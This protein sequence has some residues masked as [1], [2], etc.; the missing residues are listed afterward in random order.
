MFTGIVEEV[1]TVD[2]VRGDARILRLSVR[3]C[4]VLGETK[5]GD[6]ISV[7]GVCLTVISC[8]KE[9]FTVEIVPQTHGKTNLTD[10]KAGDPVNLERALA[11]GHRLGGHLVTGDIDGVGK[12]EHIR[13]GG[14]GSMMEIEPPRNLLKYIANQGRIAVDGVSLTVGEVIPERFR[15]YLVPFTLGHTTLG[16]KKRKSTV[17]L[18]VDLI[19]RYLERIREVEK[20]PRV[21][22]TQELLRA[23]GY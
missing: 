10:L 11:L 16:S 17:N 22:V 19:S 6:S 3:A 9:S 18:E 4:V 15:V 12:V 1:G 7:N 21:G 5:E 14:A 2:G 8:G 13:E 20:S 23:A